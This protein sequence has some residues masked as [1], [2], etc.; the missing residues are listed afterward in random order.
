MKKNKNFSPN[1]LFHYGMNVI[2]SLKLKLSDDQYESIRSLIQSFTNGKLNFDN[3]SKEC[4]SIID[5]SYPIE[6]IHKIIN[7]K[8]EKPITTPSLNEIN[9]HVKNSKTQSKKKKKRLRLKYVYENDIDNDEYFELDDDDDDFEYSKGCSK[10]KRK[11]IKNSKPQSTPKDP[12][13]LLTRIYWTE[14][15]EARLLMGVQLYGEKWKKVAEYVGNKESHMCYQ[16]WFRSVNPTLSREKWTHEED[17]KLKE[18]YNLYGEK[19]LKIARLMGNRSNQMCRDRAIKIIDGVR[20]RKYKT[21]GQT[22]SQNRSGGVSHKQPKHKRLGSKPWEID[23]S[24]SDIDSLGEDDPI[25]DNFGVFDFNNDKMPFIEK[26]PSSSS[27]TNANNNINHTSTINNKTLSYPKTR[28]QLKGQKLPTDISMKGEFLSEK[29]PEKFITSLHFEFNEQSFEIKR[30]NL[31]NMLAKIQEE[32]EIN[33]E[34]SYNYVT[35]IDNNPLLNQQPME[36]HLIMRN[37]M[38]NEMNHLLPKS[39]ISNENLNNELTNF[40]NNSQNQTKIELLENNSSC[41]LNDIDR[42]EDN[43]YLHPTRQMEVDY[44]RSLFCSDGFFND[45]FF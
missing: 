23:E 19:W 11:K 25:L 6:C 34:I 29:H 2:E 16:H 32:E 35:L 26:S 14:E 33:E 21:D 15:E 39:Q 43:K 17:Q 9:S 4:Q 40:E 38:K 3:A 31:L 42:K 27:K 41:F 28:K 20:T 8:T 24:S 30:Q 36:E 44:S 45:T 22:E 13:S 18:L 12:N 10:S 37:K 1:V 5:T 7:T